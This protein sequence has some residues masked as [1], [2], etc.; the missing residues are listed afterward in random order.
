M[1]VFTWKQEDMGGVNP[2]V[3]THRL[4]VNPSFKSVK[5]KNKSFAPERQKAINEEVG[6][7]LQAKAIRE[8]KY[9]EWLANVVL[10]KKANGKWRLCIDFIDINRACPKDSSPLPQIDLIVDAMAGHELLSFMDAFSGYNPICMDPSDQEKTSF[11][12]GQRT[13]Y[14]RV[15]A[16]R[17]KN[18]RATYQMLVNRMFQKQIGTFME[19]YIDDMLEKSLKAELH[20]THLVEAFQVLKSYNM[21]LNLA[22]CAFGVSAGKLLGFIVNN[23]GIEANL[24]K[25]KV[26]LDMLPPSNIKDI[27]R[28][29]WRIAALSASYLGSA[30]DVDLS[31]KF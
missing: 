2:A 10:V 27:Q 6:K 4:N 29:T 31:F 19:V 8:V 12:T 20:I 3:I 30:T 17:L 5:Q 18:A 16:F 23:R 26:M 7:L 14:Y 25:I 15:M 1:E 28:L 21:K 9:L 11:V 22:K 13:Y 24:D